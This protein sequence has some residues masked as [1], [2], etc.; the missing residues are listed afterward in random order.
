MRSRFWVVFALLPGVLLTACGASGG[1]VLPV[2]ALT[3]ET[4]P[5]VRY[6]LPSRPPTTPP[7]TKT[8]T[9]RRPVTT[10][11]VTA[12]PVSPPPGGTTAPPAT[13]APAAPEQMSGTVSFYSSVDKSPLGTLLIAFPTIL[14]GLAGGSGTYDDPV[15]F[16]AAPGAFAPGTRIYVPDLRRYFVLEDLCA[17]CGGTHIELWTGSALDDGIRTCEA[18]LGAQGTRSYLVS[19][20]PWLPVAPGPLYDGGGCFRP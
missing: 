19:P 2:V 1:G 8:I 12:A 7:P 11:T 14:H 4:P 13:S 5:T 10:R 6:V 16:A 17:S 15:T 18:R 20:P 9:V 3:P